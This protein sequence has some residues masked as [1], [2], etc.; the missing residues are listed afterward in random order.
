MSNLPPGVTSS[1]IPGN[2]PEDDKWEGCIDAIWKEACE[3]R[4]CADDA[5]FV[6]QLGLSAWKAFKEREKQLEEENKSYCEES[7]G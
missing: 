1:M 4:L 2:R 5:Y 3:E 6:W 7:N